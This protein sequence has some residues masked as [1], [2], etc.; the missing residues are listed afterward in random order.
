[1]MTKKRGR[2]PSFK[3]NTARFN[4]QTIPA[5]S[6]KKFNQLAKALGM[7]KNETLKAIIDFAAENKT[8]LLG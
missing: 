3:G 2:K 5:A 7:R 6:I 8:Q 1:M 4:Q